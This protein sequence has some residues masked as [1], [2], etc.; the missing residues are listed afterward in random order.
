MS[1]SEDKRVVIQKAKIS[2]PEPKV[3][4]KKFGEEVITKF[5]VKLNKKYT[6][7]E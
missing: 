6:G 5:G 1:K 3:A 4:D 2:K 7:R